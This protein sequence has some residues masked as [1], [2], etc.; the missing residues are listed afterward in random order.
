MTAVLTLNTSLAHTDQGKA[1]LAEP[2]AAFA[3]VG[4]AFEFLKEKL[5]KL[6][7]PI[8][9]INCALEWAAL[10]EHL[11][12]HAESASRLV[13]RVTAP[14]VLMALIDKMKTVQQAFFGTQ[15]EGAQAPKPSKVISAGLSIFASLCNAISWLQKTGLLTQ[16]IAITGKMNALVAFCNLAIATID[17]VEATNENKDKAQILKAVLNVIVAIGTIVL[18]A[19]TVYH[20]PFLLL[21]LGTGTLI[22]N[23]M[24]PEKEYEEHAKAVIA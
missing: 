17:L 6:E 5:D 22:L 23:I 1:V 2:Q 16:A 15:V 14:L 4:A 9:A 20:L 19:S 13:G 18:L 11:E 10:I 8:E 7:T 3:R 12:H 24:Y 21:L